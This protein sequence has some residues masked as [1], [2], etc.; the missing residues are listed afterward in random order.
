MYVIPNVAR[1]IE[2]DSI[3]LKDRFFDYWTTSEYEDYT[4]DL[5]IFEMLIYG[6]VGATVAVVAI[7]GTI[8]TLPIWCVPYMAYKSHMIR[9]ESNE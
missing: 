4:Y 8:L 6:V 2:E 7:L 5:S 9:S 3:T 1:R